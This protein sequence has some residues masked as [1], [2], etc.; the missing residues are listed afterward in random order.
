MKMSEK[1]MKN[2]WPSARKQGLTKDAPSVLRS[3]RSRITGLNARYGTL[4]ESFTK[5]A[6]KLS[7]FTSLW[8]N[9]KEDWSQPLDYAKPV[10][11]N[12]KKA[13]KAMQECG[14]SLRRWVYKRLKLTDLG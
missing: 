10:V 9:R 12:I 4:Y 2:E 5:A 11:S 14:C 8:S 13:V 1:N 7:S 6:E 3:I